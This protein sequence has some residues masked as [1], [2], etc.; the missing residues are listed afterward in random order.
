M[1][2]LLA[3]LAVPVLVT[4]V[5]TAVGSAMNALFRDHPP[6]LGRDAIARFFR[7]WMAYLAMGPLVLAGLFDGAP[8]E[9]PP[10][11]P[12]EERPPVALVPG[13]ALNRGTTWLL[14]EYLRRCGWRWVHRVNNRPVNTTVHALARRL[15]D[16]VAVLRAASG[17]DRVDLVGHSMG[18]VVAAYYINELGGH[19]YVR[20][21]VTLG[22]PWRGTR[23]HVFGWWKEARDLAPG[24]DTLA[25]VLPVKVPTTSIWSLSDQIVLPPQ[26]SAAPGLAGVHLPHIGHL[27]LL[28]NGRAWR[29]VGE[30]LAA[31]A[32]RAGLPEP[33]DGARVPESADAALAPASGAA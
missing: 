25:K 28:L 30:A 6:Q 22:T 3:I 12:A 8:R 10:S 4:F 20:R 5:A 21:L 33:V 14:A 9:S 26:S 19:R 13:F 17:A 23:Q 15:A 7:E 1:N 24:C 31:R 32:V 16:E 27:D 29:A 11:F 18:G 2:T